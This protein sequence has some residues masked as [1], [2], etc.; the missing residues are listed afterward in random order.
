MEILHEAGALMTLAEARQVAET[1]KTGW[2]ILPLACELAIGRLVVAQELSIV[3]LSGDE[4]EVMRFP[5]IPSARDFLRAELA[6]SRSM[7][8][9]VTGL[10]A[11]A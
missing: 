4:G 1:D 8:F 10:R 5:S 3:V 11:S 2:C 6:V 7:L 9:P